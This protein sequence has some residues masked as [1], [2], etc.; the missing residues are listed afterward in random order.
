[1]DPSVA[2]EMLVQLVQQLQQAGQ[3][4]DDGSIHRLLQTSPDPTQQRSPSVEVKKEQDLEC[5]SPICVISKTETFEENPAPKVYMD[6]A[7]ET[8]STASALCNVGQDTE[9]DVDGG[10]SDEIPVARR[11]RTSTTRGTKARQ[12]GAKTQPQDTS[13]SSNKSTLRS[14]SRLTVMNKDPKLQMNCVIRLNKVE[15]IKKKVAASHATRSSSDGKKQPL[16][17]CKQPSTAISPLGQSW[18]TTPAQQKSR[19]DRLK[20]IKMSYVTSDILQTCAPTELTQTQPITATASSRQPIDVKMSLPD[21]KLPVN[22]QQPFGTTSSRA[23]GTK[24]IFSIFATHTPGRGMQ[25]DEA[26]VEVRPSDPLPASVGALLQRSVNS[27]ENHSVS[28]RSMYLGFVSHNMEWLSLVSCSFSAVQKTF[29]QCSFCPKLGE[30][31][32]DVAVHIRQE[33]QVGF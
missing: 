19:V 1:M 10:D 29:C 14:I 22:Q 8:N 12:T 9:S 15:V 32:R 30:L 28:L 31:P 24:N 16:N 23:G 4:P 26:V 13:Q 25:P 6:V 11:Q 18:P 27:V 5:P 2:K 20:N 17:A 7:E 33:H 3:L 21:I